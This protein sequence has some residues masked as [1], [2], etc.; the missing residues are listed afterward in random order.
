MRA[1]LNDRVFK[2]VI[3]T[4]TKF[5]EASAKGRTILEHAPKSRGA[6][7]YLQLAREIEDMGF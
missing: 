4:D 7:E 5:R 6:Q 2:T 3:H 1:K